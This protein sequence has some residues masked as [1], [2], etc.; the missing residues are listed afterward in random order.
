MESTY[1][2]CQRLYLRLVNHLFNNN[3]RAYELEL[4]D[5]IECDKHYD[6]SFLRYLGAY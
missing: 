2:E 3:R 1:D 4:N 5:T 6:M